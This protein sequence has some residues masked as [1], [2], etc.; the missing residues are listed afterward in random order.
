[1]KRLDWRSPDASPLVSFDTAHQ[2]RSALHKASVLRPGEKRSLDSEIGKGLVPVVSPGVVALTLGISSELIR[3]MRMRPDRYY[4]LFYLQKRSGGKRTICTPRVFLKIVQWW[5]LDR[6]LTPYAE[7]VLPDCV[8]AFRP[9]RC[10]LD[11]AGPHVGARFLLRCDLADF[12]GS[13]SESRVCRL[14][15]KIGYGRRSAELLSGL[16]TVSDALPQGAPT[17][18]ALAN[19]A[20][21]P[22]DARLEQ[23][24]T[25]HSMTYTR[26]A[27]DLFFSGETLPSEK[28][29]ALIARMV[30]QHGFQLNLRKTRVMGPNERRTAVG[31]VTSC[32]AQPPR[33]LRR[34]L[35]GMFHRAQLRPAEFI[36]DSQ[37][38]YG[39]A[40]YIKMF[41]A[42]LGEKYA[43]IAE[44]VR[45]IE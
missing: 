8:C 6:I 27:D 5:I 17:S 22:C 16:T 7:A 30:G 26:Y 36:K 11:A 38:L 40:S 35:R 21:A 20:F 4:R 18:P 25:S 29:T 31:L 42:R 23:L 41:D 28:V 14:Y 43:A 45:A 37:R 44:A 34:R 9:G 15:E 13:V 1:M 2:L 3:A 19:L 32:R 24:A 12:F 39:W 10:T 33:R